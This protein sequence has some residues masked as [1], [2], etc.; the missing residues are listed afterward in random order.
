MLVGGAWVEAADGQTMP[1]HNPATG[2]VLCVV[3]KATPEDVDRAVL[4]ARHAF[5]DSAWTRTRPRERHFHADHVRLASGQAPVNFFL[6]QQ[7]RTTVV[8]RN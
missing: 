2:E 3:P 5:D 1:L 8:A 7:Q 4:A 6:G